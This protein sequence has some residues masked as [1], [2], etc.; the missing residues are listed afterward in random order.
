MILAPTLAD[1]LAA[2]YGGRSKIFGVSGKD[3]SAVAMAGHAGK[4]FWY[5]T[6]TGGKHFEGATDT[7]SDV[8][9]ACDWWAETISTQLSERRAK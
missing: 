5:S 3:R 7:W 9:K 8:K 4:A 2:Y 1:G 6:N